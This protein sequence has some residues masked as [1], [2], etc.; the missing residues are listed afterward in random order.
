MI[1]WTGRGFLSILILVLTLLLCTTIISTTHGDY[2]FII[3]FYTAGVFSYVFGI[4]WNN[5]LARTFIDK[6][7]G[8]EISFKNHHSLFWVK[9]EYWGIIFILLGIVI[10]FQNIS[11]EGMEFYFNILLGVIGIASLLVFSINLLKQ[12]NMLNPKTELQT[13]NIKT[14]S[15][16][17]FVKEEIKT[18]KF[19]NDD[20]NKYLPK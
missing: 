1:V 8:K 2:A 7:T 15:K 14:E 4:K 3:S 9:M 5:V 6:E 10:L 20:H 11:R 17:N 12:N 19:D 16:P 18:A 13:D